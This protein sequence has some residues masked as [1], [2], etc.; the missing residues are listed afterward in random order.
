MLAKELKIEEK[1]APKA[2]GKAPEKVRGQQLPFPPCQSG[3]V[4]VDEEPT[5]QA[6]ATSAA[7]EGPAARS[8][9]GLQAR[10][11]SQD[12]RGGRRPTSP[13]LR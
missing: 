11:G 5:G 3:I 7:H 6:H 12:H 9:Q 1:A 10:G 8:R 4:D 13:A 2:R